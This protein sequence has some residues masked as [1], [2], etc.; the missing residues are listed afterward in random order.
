MGPVHVGQAG[1]VA[2]AVRRAPPRGLGGQVDVALPHRLAAG[3]GPA[4]VVLTVGPHRHGIHLPSKFVNSVDGAR[5]AWSRCTHASNGLAGRVQADRGRPRFRAPASGHGPYDH[6]RIARRRAVVRHP[7]LHRAAMGPRRRITGVA[8][9]HL[10]RR[11][12]GRR[13]PPG[14]LSHCHEPA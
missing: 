10:H 2:G 11:P 1:G 4:L 5:A 6:D 3:I 13:E 14:G 8:T 12:Q 7:Q 9:R